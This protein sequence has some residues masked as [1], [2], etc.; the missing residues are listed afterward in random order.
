M[1]YDNIEVKDNSSFLKVKEGNIAH[2]HIL[3]KEPKIEGVHWIGKEKTSCVGDGC[4]TCQ[5]DK[6]KQRFKINVWDR[7]A[8]MMKAYE[9]GAGIMND[10][11]ENA[12]MLKEDGLTVHDVDFKI[13]A[14]GAG[15]DTKYTVSQVPKK[16]PCPVEYIE[17]YVEPKNNADKKDEEVADKKDEEVPF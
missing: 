2:I 17:G 5:S 12:I 13:K 6:P 11:K 15:K 9:F 16:E 8:Q 14:K 10:L 1:G 3:S 4:Q 7:K